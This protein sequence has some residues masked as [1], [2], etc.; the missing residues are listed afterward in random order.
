MVQPRVAPMSLSELH[1]P[2]E[3]TELHLTNLDLRETLNFP[4]LLYQILGRPDISCLAIYQDILKVFSGI[5]SSKLPLEERLNAIHS[6]HLNR[7]GK[8]ITDD[9]MMLV[10]VLGGSYVDLRS[11]IDNA[12]VIPGIGIINTINEN[13]PVEMRI[14][15]E[16]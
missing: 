15:L 6:Q 11:Q 14:R 12:I 1:G 8:A 9:D 10:L 3:W 4:E 13:L 2:G 7:T 5:C 16:A